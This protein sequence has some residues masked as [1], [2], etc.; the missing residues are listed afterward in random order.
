[1]VTLLRFGKAFPE[2][3]PALP[4]SKG[5]ELVEDSMAHS[6]FSHFGRGGL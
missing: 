5:G 1:M 4:F 2:I 6:T 3:P